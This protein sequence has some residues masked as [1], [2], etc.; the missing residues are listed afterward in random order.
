MYCI[1]QCTVK[2]TLQYSTVYSINSVQYSKMYSFHH[3]DSEV[4]TKGWIW[5]VYIVL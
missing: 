2:Y 4:N 3:P 1:L 5:L